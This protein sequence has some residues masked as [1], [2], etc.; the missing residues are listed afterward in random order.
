MPPAGEYLCE[1]FSCT[2]GGRN[3]AKRVGRSTWYLYRHVDKRPRLT[4]PT[5]GTGPAH[6]Q[7]GASAAAL[8]DVGAAAGQRSDGS[9]EEG[10]ETRADA[11]S[12]ASAHAHTYAEARVHPGA[13]AEPADDGRRCDADETPESS[14]TS[15][16]SSESEPEDGS[17]PDFE[18]ESA[19][20]GAT[21]P[22]PSS[23][24]QPDVSTNEIRLP[25]G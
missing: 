18:A 6:N 9:S 13:G 7:G 17:P 19:Q 3:P 22:P 23:I 4:M 2:D 21:G 14:E 11:E 15:A 8:T 16:S 10:T 1:C 25:V 12:G 5:R 24:Y 20:Q